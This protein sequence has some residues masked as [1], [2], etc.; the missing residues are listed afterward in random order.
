MLLFFF[1]VFIP[2]I[3]NLI[4]FF[5]SWLNNTDTSRQIRMN[6][7]NNLLLKIIS[8]SLKPNGML[9][10]LNLNNRILIF[11]IKK[12][13]IMM[14]WL[15]CAITLIC[16]AI[17]HSPF[18]SLFELIHDFIFDFYLKIMIRCKESRI[19]ILILILL[20]YYNVEP[21]LI[22]TVFAYC[23]RLEPLIVDIFCHFKR[24]TWLGWSLLR[25]LFWLGDVMHFRRILLS[26]I[27]ILV[28]INYYL[29]HS[30]FFSLINFIL[31][32]SFLHCI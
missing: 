16:G 23:K 25:M 21:C 30:I 9:T 13:C 10:L 29:T 17:H 7:I 15:S 3:I 12:S 32:R 11:I 5:W 4:I 14:M 27:S 1:L 18:S 8:W 20:L 19:I 28:S 24:F 26:I 2:I 22:I 31:M 6:F